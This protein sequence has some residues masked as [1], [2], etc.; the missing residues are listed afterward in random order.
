MYI[1]AAK[2]KSLVL[3]LEGITNFMYFDFTACNCAVFV[4]SH[5]LI[6][7]SNSNRQL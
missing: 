6:N 3:T 5:S 7:T 2:I 1:K 4:H